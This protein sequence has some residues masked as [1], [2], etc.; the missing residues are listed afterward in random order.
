[1]CTANT[2]LSLDHFMLFVISFLIISANI[3]SLYDEH[4]FVTLPFGLK[5]GGDMPIIRCRTT[6]RQ[7]NQAGM[8]LLDLLVRRVLAGTGS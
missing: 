4:L 1:M 7:P 5:A 3:Y 8:D 2:L 6:S